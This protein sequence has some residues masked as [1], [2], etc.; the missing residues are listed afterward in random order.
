MRSALLELAVLATLLAPSASAVVSIDWVIVR[1]PG[2][3]GDPQ[4]EED[5]GFARGPRSVPDEKR[6]ASGSSD[7]HVH[8]PVRVHV[9]GVGDALP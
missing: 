8:E 1:D 3:L 5:E 4:Q 6:P 7:D 9:S 2:N